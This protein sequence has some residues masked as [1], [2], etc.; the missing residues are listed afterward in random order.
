MPTGVTTTMRTVA[1]EC[2]NNAMNK[3][4]EV[5]TSQYDKEPQVD[6]SDDLVLVDY[7]GLM[8]SSYW[9]TT[10]STKYSQRIPVRHA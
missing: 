4:F 2:V 1:I 10:D 3:P 6:V 7:L 5:T 9:N 8:T